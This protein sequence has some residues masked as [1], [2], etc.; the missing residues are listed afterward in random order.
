ML[1]EKNKQK[2]NI[3]D[4]N[5]DLVLAYVTIRD[6]VDDL[7]SSLKQHEKYYQKD[8]KSYYYSIRESSPRNEIEKT[9]RL[10]F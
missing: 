8:S 7:I 6:R 4:L 3:S 2:C 10:L 1:T 9:S 5:T